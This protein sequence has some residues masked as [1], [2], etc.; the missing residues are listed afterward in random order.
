LVAGISVNDLLITM[1]KLC[2]WSEVMD[3]GGGDDH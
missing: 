2:R 3:V 1:E